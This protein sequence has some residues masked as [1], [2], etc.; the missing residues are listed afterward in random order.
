MILAF[1]L[2]GQVGQALAAQ[3]GV[4]ALGRDAA[5]LMDPGA[6]AAVIDKMRPD[7]VI[8]AAAFT[9]V[10]RA[11][12]DTADAMTVNAI[13]PG[14]M[15]QSC[16]A[17][18]IPFVH[19]STDYVFSGAGS[20]AWRETDT[21]GPINAYGHSKWEG[22]QAVL[23]AGA[24]AVVLRTSW[25]FSAHGQNFV[26]TMIR[27]AKTHDELRI[28]DDQIGAPT[29]ARAI[30]DAALAMARAMMGQGDLGG[31]YHFASTPDTSWA[32]FAQAIFAHLPKAPRVHKIPTM[33]YPTPAQRPM[34]SRLDCR[35]ITKSFGI[36]RPDWQAD[37]ADVMA[38]LM[39]EETDAT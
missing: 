2:N 4:C 3:P 14:I 38:Q 6:C 18:G 12:T 5:D 33:D 15:A 17:L 20:R 29:S 16:T 26:K 22:E 34:N 31:I 8:N 36:K 1:G 25:V 32:G 10:D 19:I 24:N 28:V 11:E 27:L 21:P 23:D 13:T 7:A 37:L 30:A 39:Q 9:A 35:K